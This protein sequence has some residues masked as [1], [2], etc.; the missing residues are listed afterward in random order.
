VAEEQTDAVGGAAPRLTIPRRFTRSAKT[1]EQWWRDSALWQIGFVCSQLGLDDLADTSVLD[2]G[3]GVKMTS[4]F[5]NED[6]PVKRYVG[7]DVY[8]D[9]VRFLSENVDDP[10]LEYHHL[11]LRNERYNPDGV[12]M[13]IDTRLP[14]P[15][16]SFDLIWL[17]SVFT[18]LAPPDFR[19]MLQVLRPHVKDSGH[20]FFSL[21]IDETTEG[22]HGFR[23]AVERRLEA[24]PSLR[25]DAP[26]GESEWPGFRDVYPERSLLVA[27]YTR[28]LVMELIEGTGWD[29]V[30]V[31][32]P[33][34][35]IQHSIVCRPA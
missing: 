17:F 20:L 16:E 19:L 34:Q 26:D 8:E 3:C 30:K 35:Y 6:Q 18:H 7:I 12:P 14:V 24:D 25:E 31:L 28:E 29:V 21:Y 23:D 32:D 13:S 22:G 2:M 1:D 4:A 15:L 11:P 33:H 9:M 10:R 5:V 27:S